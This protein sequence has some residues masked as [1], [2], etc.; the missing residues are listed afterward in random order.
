[1]QHS[2]STDRQLIRMM[3]VQCIYFSLLSTPIA[4]YW[5]Y[6]STV[7]IHIYDTRRIAK[8]ELWGNIVGYL[9][10]TSACTTF[11]IFTLS[12]P[13]FRRKLGYLFRHYWRSA[14]IVA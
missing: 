2:R 1:L 12:S 4:I 8:I 14:E 7:T 13:L 10:V 6:L 11:Y 9:S 5:L 3:I